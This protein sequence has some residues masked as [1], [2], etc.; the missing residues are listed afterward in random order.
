MKLAAIY[1][2]YDGVELLP[3]SI[4]QIKNHVDKIIIVYQNKSNFGEFKNTDKEL[5]AIMPSLQIGSKVWFKQ[6]TPTFKNG[7]VNERAK[8]NL[9][10]QIAKD[11]NCTHFLFMDCDE[12][13]DKF[14]ENKNQFLNSGA[15]GSVCRIITYFK[16]PTLRL[17]NYDNYYVPFIHKIYPDSV[18]GIKYPYYCDPTRGV[19]CNHVVILDFAMHHFSW[20][21]LDIEMK[22]RNS[23]ANVNQA[24]H[25]LLIQYKS[26]VQN[27]TFLHHYKQKLMFAPNLFGMPD[28]DLVKY[29]CVCGNTCL[30]P[31]K[32]DNSVC[33][34]CKNPNWKTLKIQPSYQ[35][36]LNNTWVHPLGEI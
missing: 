35:V 14:E 23:S 6:Y 10:L 4:N 34:G 12:V 13:Y 36:G 18:A 19:T 32:P 7:T 30:Q 3:F 24:V 16:K 25:D 22:V 17:T 28:F 2:V 1:N 27:G 15:D 31:Q 33:G 9:G 26:D 11:L 5:E 21:R 29:Q 20:V 8:R